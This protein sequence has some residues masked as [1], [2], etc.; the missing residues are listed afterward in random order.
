MR[1]TEQYGPEFIKCNY[2][3]KLYKAQLLWACINTIK[4]NAWVRDY[5][6]NLARVQRE[7]LNTFAHSKVK[8]FMWLFCSP[9]LPVGTQMRGK[10]AGTKCPHCYEEEDIHHMA[11]DCTTA[12]YIRKIVFKEWCSRTRDHAGSHN[13]GFKEAFFFKG[14]DTLE[15]AKRTLNDIATYHIRKY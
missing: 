14:S 7:H 13:H 10:K 6:I 11:F 3:S 8:G 12:R 9:A 5:N 4:V 2:N 1:L 15:V